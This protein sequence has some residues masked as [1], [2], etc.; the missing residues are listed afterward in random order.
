[1][2]EASAEWLTARVWS[3][4]ASLLKDIGIKESL[5][6]VDWGRSIGLGLWVRKLISCVTVHL[7][8]SDT[9]QTTLPLRGLGM[10]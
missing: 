9:G 3:K 8:V 1:M 10:M 5:Y 7:T 4:G 6:A 2:T